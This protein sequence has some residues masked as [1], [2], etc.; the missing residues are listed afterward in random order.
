MPPAPADLSPASAAL[1]PGLVH[2]VRQTMG[3]AVV[4]LLVLHDLLLARDRLA[5][6]RAVLAAEGLVV[7]GSKGQSRPHPMLAAESA[8]RSAVAAGYARLRLDESERF[9]FSVDRNG[10]LKDEF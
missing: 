2:D 8:L 6:V 4:D 10:R 9:R 7:S 3:A 5:E 1:W